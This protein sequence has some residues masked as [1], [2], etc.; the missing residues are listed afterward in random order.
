MRTVNGILNDLDNL[1]IGNNQNKSLPEDF[2]RELRTLKGTHDYMVTELDEIMSLRDER[3]PRNKRAL[4]PVVGE[5]LRRVKF[6]TATK[7][8]V[9]EINRNLKTLASNQDELIH[10]AE[11]SLS[12][13][14]VTRVEVKQ[15]DT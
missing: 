12:I 2:R 10:I 1:Q 9:R 6:G 5:G 14:N 3:R 7:S 8:Y 11:E 15:N 13:L 4:I